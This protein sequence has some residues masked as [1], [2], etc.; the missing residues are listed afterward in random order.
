MKRKRIGKLL[1]GLLAAALLVG[2]PAP[3]MASEDSSYTLGEQSLVNAGKDG[4]SAEKPLDKDDPHWGWSLGKFYVKGYTRQTTVKGKP[5]FLK[6]AGDKVGLWFSLTQDIDRLNGNDKL[7]IASDSDGWDK[8]LGIPQQNFGRGMLIVK[9][10]DYQNDSKTNT[11]VDFLAAGKSK[12]ADTKVQLFEEGDYEVALDYAVK[13]NNV[14]LLGWKP[15]SSTSYYRVSFAFSIRN[16]NSMVFPKDVKTGSELTNTAFTENGFS[17]DLA[18]SH[19]LDVNVRKSVLNKG[20][21]GLVEDTRFNRPAADGQ[22]YTEEGVYTITVTNRYTDEQT[23]KIIYVGTDDVLKAYATT[24]MTI[25]AIKKQISEGATVSKDGSLLQPGESQTTNAES[26]AKDSVDAPDSWFSRG[27]RYLIVAS[28]ILVIFL[29]IAF[30]S[31]HRHRKR[32]KM[33]KLLAKSEE[34]PQ[35]E[36]GIAEEQE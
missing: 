22:T 18:E 33:M 7:S 34:R 29:I 12:T 3:A 25:K 10:T 14:S 32:S 31:I 4:Y 17:I 23:T 35:L 9:Q 27:I 5:L 30:A 16:G 36:T 26:S 6:N 8:T 21:D 20:A 2:L 19:Y 11:Y 13:K 15:F 1:S 24:G 28:I